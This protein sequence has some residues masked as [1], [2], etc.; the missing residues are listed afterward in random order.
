LGAGGV[1]IGETGAQQE[2][3]W[4]CDG[5]SITDNH[6]HEAGRV[7]PSAV[8]VLILQS[9]KNH[10]AHNEIDHLFYTAISCGWTWGYRES[11]CRENIIEFNHLHHMGQAMLSDMGGVYTLGPQKGTVIRNNLIHDVESYTYGG[12]G[13]YTDEGSSHIVL[14]SN[15]VYNT[16]TGGFHQHYGR[17]NVIQNNI[18]AD[19][20]QWQLQMTRAEDHLSFSFTNNIVCWTQ[21][22]LFGGPFDKGHV[23]LE[24]NLYWDASGRAVDFAPVSLQWQGKN[25]KTM[26]AAVAETPKTTLEQWQA[27]GHDQGSLVADPKFVAPEKFDFR[28][29]AGSP[30]FALGFKPIDTSK[31]G[32]RGNGLRGSP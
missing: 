10:V 4:Q 17:D 1:R 26:I 32:V 9:G 11:P 25:I 13:L 6:I 16:K 29:K 14:E 12:W 8:G 21:G 7:F 31:V 18:F 28:L 3:F 19:S 24:K 20:R 15:I 30:A 2:P 27:R 23:V 5:H 22:V